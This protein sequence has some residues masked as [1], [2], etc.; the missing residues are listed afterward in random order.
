VVDT[1]YGGKWA[2]GKWA[3]LAGRGRCMAS[4]PEWQAGRN[5]LVR[6]VPNY[7]SD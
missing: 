1:P 5:G 6:L 2:G 4:R 3:W 7:V